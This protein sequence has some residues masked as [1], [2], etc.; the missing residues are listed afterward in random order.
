[1]KATLM[2]SATSFSLPCASPSILIAFF[3]VTYPFN[4]SKPIYQYVLG[5][6]VIALLVPYNDPRLLGGDDASASPFVLAAAN[7]GVKVVP[8]IVNAVVLVAAWSAG[9]S[10]VVSLSEITILE[11][12]IETGRGVRQMKPRAISGTHENASA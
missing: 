11:P 3:A 12:E 1:M 6:L 4:S 10:D 5:I 8:H 2:I 9:N 7:A